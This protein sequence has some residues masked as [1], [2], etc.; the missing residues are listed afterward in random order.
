MIKKFILKA[1]NKAGYQVSKLEGIVQSPSNNMTTGLKRLKNKEIEIQTVIDIG[2]S[3]GMWAEVCLRHYPYANYYLI[4]AQEGHRAGLDL[5]KE[6]HKNVDYIIAAAG[7]KE[8]EI[9]F[10]NGDLFGGL[11][12]EN[13]TD[14]RKLIKVPVTTID[15]EVSKNNLQAPYLIKLDTHGFEIPILEGAKETLKNS[16]VVVIEV[17]NF[18]IADK[19]LRFW[20]MCTYMEKL[21][22][23]PI[24]IV[25]VVHRLKDDSLWQFD[26]I[27][28]KKDRKEFSY[29]GYE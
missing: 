7:E 13:P 4:E 5:F 12:I 23:L 17:Y 22:F 16:N 21:G 1:I 24:D 19:S 14:N 2:A 25:D 11:A 27:F 9:Y 10:D 8:G 26:M 29:N 15:I 20:E 6:K 28:I 3:N 18:V